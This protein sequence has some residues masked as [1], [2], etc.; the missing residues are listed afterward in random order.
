VPDVGA[1]EFDPTYTVV[2]TA[3][4]ITGKE[5]SVFPSLSKGII[6]IEGRNIRR[7]I[8]MDING[9]IRKII[10]GSGED[11]TSIDISN[12]ARGMYLLKVITGASIM[13]EKVILS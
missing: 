5:V 13:V 7:I 12:E 4:H 1:D 3:N 6:T 9:Q 8:I 10:T 2:G 11:R